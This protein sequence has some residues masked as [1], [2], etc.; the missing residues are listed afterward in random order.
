MKK[1]VFPYLPA[2]YSLV[3][4]MSWE[5]SSAFSSAFSLASLR[6]SSSS[7]R[8]RCDSCSSARSCRMLFW[9]GSTPWPDLPLPFSCSMMLV[10]ASMSLKEMHIEYIRPLLRTPED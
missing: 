3:W 1:S 4:A 6:S 9:R 2:S 8:R 10:D 5:S 7:L